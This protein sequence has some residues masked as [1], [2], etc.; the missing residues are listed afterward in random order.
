VWRNPNVVQA[1]P[2]RRLPSAAGGTYEPFA[3][4]LNPPAHNG[5]A[6]AAEHPTVERGC[7]YPRRGDPDRRFCAFQFLPAT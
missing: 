4:S 1:M 3:W 2:C 7:L 5:A 6:I